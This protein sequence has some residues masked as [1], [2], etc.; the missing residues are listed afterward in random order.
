[1]MSG[2]LNNGRTAAAATPIELIKD[3]CSIMGNNYGFMNLSNRSI[4]AQTRANVNAQVLFMPK[5][6]TL[7]EATV[8]A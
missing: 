7:K 8:V 6:S 5:S 3:C 4:R 1:M 2:M